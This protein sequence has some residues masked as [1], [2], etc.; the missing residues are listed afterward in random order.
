VS[1]ECHQLIFARVYAGRGHRSRER[2]DGLASRDEATVT[3]AMR[4]AATR[5]RRARDRADR[6][7]AMR[8]DAIGCDAMRDVAP[9]ALASPCRLPRPDDNGVCEEPAGRVDGNG[10][11]DEA[12]F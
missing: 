4:V 2:G 5:V 8:W 12:E 9:P 10:M 3:R 1:V 6:C 11:N 7:D